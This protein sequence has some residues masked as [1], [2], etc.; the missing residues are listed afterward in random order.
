MCAVQPLDARM[1]LHVS[2]NAPEEERTNPKLSTHSEVITTAGP[3]ISNV[4]VKK[5][6]SADCFGYNQWIVIIV[7]KTEIK[8]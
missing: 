1:L 2:I 6:G 3:P 5:I 7:L 8:T 4:E